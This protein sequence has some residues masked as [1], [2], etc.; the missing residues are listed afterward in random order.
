MLHVRKCKIDLLFDIL[1]LISK[2]QSIPRMHKKY[3][4]GILKWDRQM[5]A[6]ETGETVRGL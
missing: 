3:K 4:C 2:F 5:D 6:E 1:K